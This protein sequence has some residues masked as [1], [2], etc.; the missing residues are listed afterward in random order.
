MSLQAGATTRPF[1]AATERP[2]PAS[3]DDPN[4]VRTVASSL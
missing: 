3:A 1:V 2:E 4:L